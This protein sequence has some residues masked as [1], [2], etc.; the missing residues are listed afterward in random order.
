M[1]ATE[2]KERETVKPHGPVFAQRLPDAGLKLFR[3]WGMYPSV[4]MYTNYGLK[5][6]KWGGGGGGG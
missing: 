2:T 1:G 6:F 5:Q 3:L 4:P